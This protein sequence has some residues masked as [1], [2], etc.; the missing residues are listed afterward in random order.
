MDVTNTDLSAIERANSVF[1]KKGGLLR[2]AVAVRAGIH[3]DTLRV[4][5]EQGKLEK[6]SRG[7]YQLVGAPLPLA[8]RSSGRGGKGTRRGDLPHF[9]TRI[10]R[11]DDTDSA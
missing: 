7:L 1:R 8:S 4:M 5:V 9:G 2:M 3:R 11:V 6:I 10:S